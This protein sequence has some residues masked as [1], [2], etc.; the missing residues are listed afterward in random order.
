MARILKGKPVANA[1]VEELASKLGKLKAGQVIP[2]LAVLRVGEQS[3]SV[4]YERATQRRMATMGIAVRTVTL[5]ETC[6]QEQVMGAIARIN[7][8]ASIHGCLMLRPLPKSLDEQ[9]ACEALD[10]SKD[11]DGITPVSIY[12]LLA[13]K[14]GGFPPC[15]AEA[16]LRML[17]HYEIEPAG[18]K[19]VVVGRSLVIGKPVAAMLLNRDATVTVCHTKTRGLAEVCQQADIVV[20][21]AGSRGMIGTLCARPGQVVLDVGTNWDAEAG[22]LVGDVAFDELEPVVA[23]LSPV[24]GGIG[25]ITTAVL[26]S[27]VVEAAER[28]TRVCG[29]A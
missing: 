12:A 24:P 8:D 23:A 29:Q 26:A 13:R 4:S 3:E 1:L 5:P 25:S 6:T 17:D 2:T 20:A 22:K 19:A 28:S 16:C 15:T 18:K 27:H 10:A 14:R 7:D 11:V 9:A 21:A